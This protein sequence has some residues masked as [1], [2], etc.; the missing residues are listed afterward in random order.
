MLLLLKIMLW[1]VGIIIVSFFIVVGFASG[2]MRGLKIMS[3]K[4]YPRTGFENV[5]LKKVLDVEPNVDPYL[6]SFFLKEERKKQTEEFKSE[7]KKINKEISNAK[8]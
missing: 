7:V 8:K 4:D 6:Y 5:V 1:I 3:I 2:L